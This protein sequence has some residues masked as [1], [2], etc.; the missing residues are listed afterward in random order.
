MP[1]GK[2]RRKVKTMTNNTTTI[3]TINTAADSVSVN[4]ARIE[5]AI[6]EALISIDSF[7]DLS[8]A[9][10]VIALQKAAQFLAKDKKV[11]SNEL[12][13]TRAAYNV[14]KRADNKAKKAATPSKRKPAKTEEQKLAELR[15]LAELYRPY[16]E[17]IPANKAEDDA[18]KAELRAR[19]AAAG[20][21]SYIKARNAYVKL[22]EN[23][24]ATVLLRELRIAYSM[25]IRE[26]DKRMPALKKY[27]KAHKLDLDHIAWQAL[28]TREQAA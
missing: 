11:G 9:E 12:K 1:A 4:F 15:A 23:G 7:K 18:A 8:D 25:T 27:A 2:K 5:S 28:N 22:F 13:K 16:A 26:M 19:C 10:C 21:K 20:L 14:D 6:L 3:N 17:F 24:F